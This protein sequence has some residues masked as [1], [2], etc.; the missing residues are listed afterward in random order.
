MKIAI[1]VAAAFALAACATPRPASVVGGECRVFEQPNHP[2]KGKTKR[3]QAW[4]DDTVESG[5]A[6]CGW[7]RP[8]S[9]K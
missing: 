8:K 4:I 1:L 7:N 5:I 9:Q 6:A 3:D 2:V